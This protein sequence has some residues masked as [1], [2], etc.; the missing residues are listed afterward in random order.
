M[1]LLNQFGKKI[2]TDFPFLQGKKLLIACSGGVDSVVLA[3]LIRE[4]NFEMALAHCNFSLRGKESDGDEIFVIGMAKRME[5]PVFAETFDTLA[6]SHQ[7]GVSTQMAARTLRYEWFNSLLRNFRYDYLLTAHHLDDDLET[8]FINLSRGTGIS[9]L[10]GIPA[11]NS[12]TVRPLL[13]FSREEIMVFA[14]KKGLKWREDSS[15]QK[16][17]YLRNKLRLELLPQ[18]KSLSNTTLENFK[19]T[20]NNLTA[21][22]NLVE[23]YMS[24]I[25]KLVIT[26]AADH[27]KINIGKLKELPH[28]Q[29]ILYELLNV[30][31]FT[32]WE[33]I[34]D[35]LDAQTGKQVLSKSHRLIKNREELI[36]GQRDFHENDQSYPVT[37]NG[38]EFPIKLDF[39][40]VDKVGKLNQNQIYIDREKANFPMTLR[41]WREGDYFFPF[42]MDG[43]K[44]LSKYFKDEKMSL[45]EKEAIW[46]LESENHIVW[47]VG[48]R[49]DE[50]FKVENTTERI[51]QISYN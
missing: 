22:R 3:T 41:R 14:Q 5:I 21:T 40:I 29:A 28:P 39:Q 43:K 33:N 26:E 37:E 49:M 50:R 20:K 24:I 4:L 25:Y 13:S 12:K 2:K 48:F 19:K 38:L 51:L 11:I 35:L 47:I 42:G 44:K 15:N 10:L 36:L 32:E 27:Y 9:G 30:F 34:V 17:D 7:N 46:L 8:F 6:F 23:D 16:S 31:G 45:M 18:F 1:I